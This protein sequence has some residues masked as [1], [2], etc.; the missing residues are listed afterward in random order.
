[1]LARALTDTVSRHKLCIGINRDKC[2]LIA[3]SLTVVA[4]L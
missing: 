2:P 4:G 1:M 3:K